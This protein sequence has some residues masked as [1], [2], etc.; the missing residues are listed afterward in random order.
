MRRLIFA[1]IIAAGFAAP[2]VAVAVATPEVPT[3]QA[4]AALVLL[5]SGGGLIAIARRHRIPARRL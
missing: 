1:A 4:P 3:A 2:A 5:L